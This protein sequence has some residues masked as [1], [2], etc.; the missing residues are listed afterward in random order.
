MKT[1]LLAIGILSLGS[2]SALTLEELQKSFRVKRL[3]IENEEKTESLRLGQNYTKALSKIQ[4]NYQKAGHLDRVLMVQKEIEVVGSATWPLPPLNEEA[5]SELSRSRKIFFKQALTIR[6]DAAKSIIKVT[7]KMDKLL[8]DKV[9]GLTKSGDLEGAQATKK[10]K[11][12]LAQDPQLV[13]ARSLLKSVRADG[14]SLVALRIRRAG[15]N[16]E[17]LVRYDSSGKIS[18]KSPIENVIEHTGGKDQKGETKAK[19]LGEFLGA[20]GYTVDPYT[21]YSSDL[22]KGKLGEM[23]ATSLE[24]D[25]GKEDSGGSGTRIKLSLNPQNPHINFSKVLPP[26][27]E[28]G[29]YRVQVR[30]FVPKENKAVVG[31]QFAQGVGPIPGSITTKKGK[32]EDLDF[33]AVS[34]NE[35]V[36]LLFYLKSDPIAANPS[37]LEEYV[38]ISRVTISHQSF[39]AYIVDR[40]DK[41]G[42]ATQISAEPEDQKILAENGALLPF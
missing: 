38:S 14:S 3:K 8:G 10:Y 25:F 13:A 26:L 16:L 31:I 2:A 23:R 18:M 4:V 20:K 34:A 1:L 9:I 33:T 36:G 30:Y 27:L 17:V 15:D 22:S 39:T 19:T 11:E 42:A 35:H 7:D 21:S 5:P 12:S 32:W 29:T 28:K 40:F 37:N 41:D 24:L 6:Q